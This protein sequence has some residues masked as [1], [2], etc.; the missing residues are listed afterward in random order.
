VSGEREASSAP[1]RPRWLRATP[2]LGSPPPLTRRQWRVL[3]L[4]SLATLFDQYDRALFALALPKI[5]AS[6][7]IAEADVGLLASIVRLG[8]LPAFLATLAADRFGRRR[9][10]LV[11]I[12]GYTLCTGLT[13]LAPDTETFIALQFLTRVF[14]T[15]EILLAVVVITEEL[16]AGVRGWGV[17]ALFAIQ[18]CGVGVAAILLPV[19]E[20][21]GL[22]WRALYAVGLGPLVVLTYWRRTLPE[23]ARFEAA[24]R[25]A[26]YPASLFGP[27]AELLRAYR[28]RFAAVAAV[29]F[30]FSAGGAAGDFLAPKY[31]LDAHGWSPGAV[32]ILYVL[33]G[34]LGIFGAAFAGRLSDRAGRKPIAVVFAVAVLSLALAFFNLHGMWLAPAWVALIFALMGYDVLFNSFGAELF[35]TSQR[36]TASGARAVTATLGGAVGLAAESVLY[37]W[38]GSHWTA[39]SVL[40]VVAF[41]APLVI[42][43]AFPETAGRSLEEIA[44]EQES[45]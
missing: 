41:L 23:T 32:A 42:A 44:P 5:Q 10:L 11:T 8:S 2:F 30:V 34:G 1:Y 12:V 43:L 14:G 16:D 36:S 33:G 29:S 19:V 20:W 4:V 9:V 38:F 15:A 3:G 37:G 28:G 35:P 25:N 22:G 40:L 21:L 7:A 26:E 13:A 18:A 45:P 27:M 17:G 6:L 31:L 39:V 24:S